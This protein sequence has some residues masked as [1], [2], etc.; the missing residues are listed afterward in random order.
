MDKQKCVFCLK[1]IDISDNSKY[2]YDEEGGICCKPC[3]LTES[4]I[5][6]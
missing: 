3:F 5:G 4:D 2:E 1:D 6:E